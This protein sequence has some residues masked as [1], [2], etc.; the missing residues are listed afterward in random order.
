MRAPLTGLLRWKIRDEATGFAEG[1]CVMLGA[2]RFLI[3]ELLGAACLVIVLLCCW[4]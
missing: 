2:E 4:S 1:F 3:A